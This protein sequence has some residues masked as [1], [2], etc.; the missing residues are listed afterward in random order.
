MTKK[1]P[2]TSW[3]IICFSLFVACIFGFF[4]FFVANNSFAEEVARIGYS[5]AFGVSI[6]ELVVVLRY[7]REQQDSGN[8]YCLYKGFLNDLGILTIYEKREDEEKPGIPN[9]I[10]DLHEDLVRLKSRRPTKPTKMMGVTLIFY[11]DMKADK[12]AKSIA[13]EIKTT[14]ARRFFRL[15]TFRCLSQA[16]RFLLCSRFSRGQL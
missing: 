2:A 11:F 14:S 6:A 1:V 16:R 8:R 12:L 5:L 15:C 9:Y 4:S 7:Y 13:S 10:K 3:I